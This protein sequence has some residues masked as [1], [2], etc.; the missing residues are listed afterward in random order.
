MNN[1]VDFGIGR[2]RPSRSVQVKQDGARILF[3]TGVRYERTEEDDAP[4]FVPETERFCENLEPAC[5]EG[6]GMAFELATR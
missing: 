4:S 5:I 3:F 6:S 2:T 1:I